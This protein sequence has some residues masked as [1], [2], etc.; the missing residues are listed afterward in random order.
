MKK[1]WMFLLTVVLAATMSLAQTKKSADQK[2]AT[3]TEK[4]DKKASGALD[5]GETAA[6]KID[7]NSASQDELE[8]LNGIGPVTAKKIIDGRPYKTKR[9]LLTKKVVSQG[10]YDKI[11]DS[12]IAHQT[13]EASAK[14]TTTKATTTKKK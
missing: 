4:S 14:S 7:V 13:G 1:F 5:A 3:K 12:I 9:D 6:G 11:K 2:A 10:E 8:K